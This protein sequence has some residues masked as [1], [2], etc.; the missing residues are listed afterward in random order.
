MAVER[1]AQLQPPAA[2]PDSAS[3]IAPELAPGHGFDATPPAVLSRP[4]VSLAQR[5]A[6]ARGFAAGRPSRVV[7]RSARVIARSALSDEVSKLWDPANKAPFFERLRHLDQSDLD[8][9]AWVRSNLTGNDL[10]LAENLVLNGP[11]K[12]WPIQLRVEREMKG[13]PDSKGKGA[14]FDI[15]RTANAGEAGNAELAAALVRVFA[16]GSDDLWLGQQLQKYGTETKFPPAEAEELRKRK[17]VWEMSSMV[18]QGATWTP[19]GGAATRDPKD[20]SDK[21]NTFAA[22]AEAPTE[23]AAP[24]L[25]GSTT[26]N[27]WEMVLLAAYRSGLLKWQWIH[28]TYVAAKADWGAYLAKRLIPGAR[29]VYDRAA[30]S[31]N[32]GRGDIVLWNG[33]SH[34]GL[35]LG[36]RD[37]SGRAEVLSFWPPP[38]K[39]SIPATYDV[40]KVTTIEQLADYMLKTWPADPLTVEFGNPPW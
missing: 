8:L 33:A 22:W 6:L 30:H 20:P 7:G 37:G 24:A 4:G 38:D 39:P 25:T 26:I 5:Q 36:T 23:A 13:F 19:S 21:P 34:V 2:A 14:V 28:D 31:P 12:G 16:P 29:T 3:E 27:C 40:V 1:E 11:E 10:W 18:G 15:L 32:P 17:V 9:L 35:A